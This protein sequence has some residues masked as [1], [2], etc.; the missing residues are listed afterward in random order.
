M[1]FYR[2]LVG[3]QYKMF[4]VCEMFVPVMMI[5]AKNQCSTERSLATS[6]LWQKFLLSGIMMAV[7]GGSRTN[8]W[9][10]NMFL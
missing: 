7:H 5:P 4:E 2:G 3:W 9:H 10:R 8:I 6:A 1:P